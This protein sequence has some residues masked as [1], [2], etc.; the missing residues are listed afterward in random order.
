MRTKS[1]NDK[2]KKFLTLAL[3]AV[4]AV[5]TMTA[6]TNSSAS[7]SSTKKSKANVTG[8]VKDSEDASALVRATIQ[9]M[10]SDTSRMVTGGVT[11]TLG[12]YTIKNVEE[13]SYIVKVSYIGYHNFF[14]AITIKNGETI[15]NVGTVLLTPNSVLL[16]TAVVQGQLPQMEV[17]E[18]TIIFNAD[19]FKIPEGSVLEDL[20]KKL[21]GAEVSSDGTIKI[22][23]KTISKILVDGKEFFSSDKDI[24]MKNLP[25]E[26]VDKVKTYDKASDSERLTGIAD[27]NEE[28]VIDLT[29]KKGMKQGW[30]GNINLG[31]G[32][33][34][35][36]SNRVMVNRFK[37]N[38]QSS[39]IGNLNTNGGGGMGSG[40]GGT[41]K[42]LNG[43]VGLNLNTSK[44][45]KYEIGGNVRYNGRHNENS[46][47][48][49]S[50][51]YVSTRRSFSDRL[52]D[53]KSHSDNANAEFKIEIQLDTAT[54]LLMRP[55]VGISNSASHSDG[56]SA[57]Y[58]SD[59]YTFN[60]LTNP[61]RQWST[62]ES[63]MSDSIVNHN[64]TGSR[65]F[66]DSKNASSSLM[67]NRRFYNKQGRNF[68]LNG[69]FNYSQSDGRNYNYSDVTY[70]Q[71]QTEPSDLIYRYRTSPNIN[72][73]FSLGFTYSEPI[74]KNLILQMSYNYSYSYRKSDSNTFNLGLH[75]DIQAAKEKLAQMLGYLPDSYFD[76]LSDSLSNYSRDVNQNHNINLSV[77]WNTNFIT[78]SVGV[79][80]QPQRQHLQMTYMGKDIDTT[81][82]FFRISPTLN[83]RYRFNRQNQLNFS[84]RG[85]MNQPAITDL[86]T[87]TDDSNPLNIRSGNPDL[88]P[89]FSNNFRIGWNNYLTATMQ[90]IFLN[91][92]FS[93]TLNS[94]S[95]QTKYNDMTGASETKPM[96][97]NG[98][99]NVDGD[100]GF[101]TPLFSMER[102]MLN[103]STSG[104][105]SNNV[106]YLYRNNESLKNKT[107][108]LRIGER[109]SLT[110]RAEYWDVRLNGNFS[111]NHQ[112]N[113][114]ID[115][116]SPNTYD[117]SYGVES[118]GNFDNGFGYATNLSVS[119]RRGYASSEANTNELIWNAQVS[120]R[121]LKGRAATI[122]LQAY[123]LLNQRSNFSRSISAYSRTDTWTES[124]NSYFMVNFM[125]RFNLFGSKEAR[126][127]LRQERQERETYR[128][129]MERERGGDMGRDRGGDG[130]RGGGDR[131]GMGGGDR[132]GMGGMGGGGRF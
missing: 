79:Q 51:N 110:Y 61:L 23:G 50:E 3:M 105:Y 27:G 102:L 76:Y 49:A 22:N 29:I 115:V 46:S 96:N 2:M 75:P 21:P 120:Y 42:N 56:A 54:T 62:L 37:D 83:F 10:T 92:S 85:N 73:S 36:Y 47:R 111:Y 68:S 128:A 129:N 58:Y 39:I 98:N 57:R 127:Q 43:S 71:R 9:I 81:R 24:A 59:P 117:F 126:Q 12:G 108:N 70:Y 89:S 87:I 94:I 11:N 125:Y 103:T 52:S 41:G 40:R 84:Y 124:V 8:Y 17:K 97:I 107:N 25:A 122:S 121:F 90:T 19:A 34:D 130:N 69:N 72:K 31:V 100:F 15:H 53:N 119:S 88:K 28:T 131:G 6:Q 132:G 109:L 26:I 1:T 38:F 112:D 64:L 123:D 45:D 104:S 65:S 67:L 44:D 113:R 30:F 93:N 78:S 74:V 13:G 7:N 82:N 60:E 106:S 35:Q 86:I 114:Y 91:A 80:I 5:M 14:R 118:N 48:S 63:L 116:T 95:S 20:I 101:N 66:S 16:E 99:W 33:K 4:L 55:Q 77:R 18:D 32:T